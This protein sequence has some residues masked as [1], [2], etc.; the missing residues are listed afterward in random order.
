MRSLGLG[1]LV[2]SGQKLRQLSG[3]VTQVGHRADYTVVLPHDSSAASLYADVDDL[4][5]IAGLDA[6][7][8]D[9]THAEDEYAGGN[10]V[11]GVLLAT[12][13]IPVLLSDS[14]EVQPSRASQLMWSKRLCRRLQRLVGEVNLIKQAAAQ[15]LWVLAASTGG[16]QPVREFLQ[17]LPAGLDT[18]FLYAQHIDPNNSRSLT[19]MLGRNGAYQSIAP[20]QGIVLAADT[21][22]IM[23]PAQRAQVLDNATLAVYDEPWAGCYQPSIDQ[24]V[25]NVAGIKKHNSGVIVFSGMGAD[26]AVSCQFLKRQGGQVWTQAPST[27]VVDAMPTA[28][29]QT[30]CADFSGTPA[31]LAAHFVAHIQHTTITKGAVSS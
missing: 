4:E 30:G 26:G 24:L 29:L 27:C 12:A 15:R 22:T 14:S 13:E 20:E 6:W 17:A 21:V 28:V 18:S 9:I 25:T 8:V 1:L 7:L 19:A 3:L 23:N 16:P 31:Q 5:R 2:D 10:K 11:L